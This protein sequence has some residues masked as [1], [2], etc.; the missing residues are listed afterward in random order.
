MRIGLIYIY[1]GSA[2][3]KVLLSGHG[4]FFLPKKE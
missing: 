2:S 3:S 1:S 4:S